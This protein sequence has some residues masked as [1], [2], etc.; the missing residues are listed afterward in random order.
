MY[1]R[2]RTRMSQNRA[3][4]VTTSISSRGLTLGKPRCKWRN[5]R[6][7]ICYTLAIRLLYYGVLLTLSSSS[8][9]SIFGTQVS[10][11]Y[12]LA[13]ALSPLSLSLSLCI[14][15]ATFATVLY[16]A[17]GWPTTQRKI[18]QRDS[19]LP[20]EWVRDSPRH[21]ATSATVWNYNGIF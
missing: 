13:V 20:A 19:V 16:F 10:A 14:L 7:R 9:A 17:L 11:W 12:V 21:R 2:V 15:S 6:T 5:E 4:E 8:T 18:E 3:N 1:T